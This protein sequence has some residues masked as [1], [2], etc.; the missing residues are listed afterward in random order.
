MSISWPNRLHKCIISHMRA[1][2]KNILR[3]GMLSEGK[4]SGRVAECSRPNPKMRR[5]PKWLPIW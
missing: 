2:R 5:G 1:K 3:V 4:S